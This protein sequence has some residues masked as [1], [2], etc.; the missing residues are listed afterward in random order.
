MTSAKFKTFA[1]A[2]V[3]FSVTFFLL[4]TYSCT[5]E[6]ESCDGDNTFKVAYI[7]IAECAQLY[8]AKEK[9]LF[10][11]HGLEVTLVSASG[12]QN[13]IDKLLNKEVDASFAS[14][15]TFLINKANQDANADK[16]YAAFGASYET[17][18]NQNHAIFMS[19]SSYDPSL[20]IDNIQKANLKFGINET[21]RME[22]TFLNEYLKQHGIEADKIQGQISTFSFSNLFNALKDG[23]VDVAC[24]VEPQ[25]TLARRDTAN[26]VYLDNHYLAV[27]ANKPIPVATYIS[28]YSICENKSDKLQ[29]FIDAMNEATE[30]LKANR[31]ECNQYI[32]AYTGIATDVMEGMGLPE[33]RKTC[34]KDDLAK[35]IERINSNGFFEGK[36]AP[37]AEDA[38]KSCH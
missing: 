36:A 6:C 31:L 29:H 13:S 22:H 28:L 27:N 34:E 37:T 19:R 11:K 16:I 3:F 20:G 5:R 25:I 9:G 1:R 21:K 15:A 33:F 23:A 18:D 24:M 14:I 4:S 30:Y 26:F 2:S 8:V 10:A 7:P 17:P 35:I 38:L 12:G 32:S